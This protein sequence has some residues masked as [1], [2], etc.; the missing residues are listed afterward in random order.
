MS[1]KLDILY[2]LDAAE[3]AQVSSTS[4]V[5]VIACSTGESLHTNI[6]DPGPGDSRPIVVEFGRSSPV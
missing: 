1:K 2:F 6:I 4:S 3:L 5:D